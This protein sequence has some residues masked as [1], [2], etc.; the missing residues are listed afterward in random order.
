MDEAGVLVQE[1]QGLA[2]LQQSLLNLE[3]VNLQLAPPP[4][5]VG[6]LGHIAAGPPADTTA[7]FLLIFLVQ[8]ARQRRRDGLGDK[9]Q[10]ASSC[11]LDRLDELQHAGMAQLRE[12]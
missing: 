7:P 3:L 1:L 4:G 10:T 12:R 8:Q 5:A 9:L 11:L 2:Y 6:V